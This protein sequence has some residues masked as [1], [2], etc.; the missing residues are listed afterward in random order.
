MGGALGLYNRSFRGYRPIYRTGCFV[1]VC[2][3]KFC[4]RSATGG[5]NGFEDSEGPE[6]GSTSKFKVYFEDGYR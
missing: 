1:E 2:D 5:Q 4:V 3:W 6:I